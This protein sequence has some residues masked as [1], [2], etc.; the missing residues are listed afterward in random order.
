MA[1]R[2]GASEHIEELHLSIFEL[3]DN[4]TAVE[5]PLRHSGD[6]PDYEFRLCHF[7]PILDQV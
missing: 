3:P 6:D 1:T 7:S 2:D 5:R 4:Y